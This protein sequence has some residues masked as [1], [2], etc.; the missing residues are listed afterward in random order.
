MP[1]PTAAP[2]PFG[3]NGPDLSTRRGAYLITSVR[4]GVQFDDIIA[5]DEYDQIDPQ[6]LFEKPGFP[7]T[8]LV[9]GTGDVVVD[10]KFARQA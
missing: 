2:P 9:Q 10:P 4:N 8:F 5:E 3:P 1:P 7:P 6:L